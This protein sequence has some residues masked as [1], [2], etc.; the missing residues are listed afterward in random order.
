MPIGLRLGLANVHEELDPGLCRGRTRK[1][2]LRLE[3][4]KCAVVQTEVDVE[5]RHC[6][7][8][9]HAVV[10]DDFRIHAGRVRTPGT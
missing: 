1:D 9:A 10:N 8:Q 5:A 3:G 2:R 7:V 6:V 4:E